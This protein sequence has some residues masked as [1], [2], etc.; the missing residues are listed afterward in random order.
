MTSHLISST[1]NLSSSS[2]ELNSQEELLLEDITKQNRQMRRKLMEPSDSS[3]KK[4]SSRRVPVRVFVKDTEEIPNMRKKLKEMEKLQDLYKQR[5]DELESQVC[6]FSFHSGKS[7]GS[8]S[9]G[10]YN[11][12]LPQPAKRSLHEPLV[13]SSSN[14]DRI[15]SSTSSSSSGISIPVQPAFTGLPERLQE[16]YTRLS[17]RTH[18]D[19]TKLLALYDYVPQ[20]DAKGRLPF[21]EGDVLLLVSMKSRS[22][23]WMA[24]LN[25]QVGKIPSNYVEQLDPSRAFKAR[26]VKNFDSAQPGDMAIQRGGFVTVLKRQDNGW[27]LGEK[28][29]KTGFFPSSCVERVISPLT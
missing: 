25:G 20:S 4:R 3:G 7:T 19:R 16:P 13:S 21:K 9:P 22:G 26:I 1:P 15:S 17:I 11:V 8:L 12:A 29:G 27:Y 23:W 6:N 24:E 14:E 2:S 28:S 10:P 5:I 18:P